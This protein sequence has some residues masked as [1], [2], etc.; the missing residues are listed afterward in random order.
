[1]KEKYLIMKCEE[2]GDP[3]ECDCDRTPLTM[4]ENWQEWYHENKDTIKY[5]FEVYEFK[6]NEFKL[7]KKY[8]DDSMKEK[9]MALYYWTEEQ[10]PEEDL[11]TIVYEY[12]NSTRNNPIPKECLPF[13][14]KGTD[15]DNSL[16]GCGT[17]SFFI[18]D[19]Y[20]VYGEYWDNNEYS[21]GY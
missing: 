11:P 14:E 5:D 8:D 7:I 20:Y 10:D 15:L 3:Y 19:K 2:L 13:I 6:N 16:L 12:K 4:C 18:D 21:L 1:M 17:I 9:G